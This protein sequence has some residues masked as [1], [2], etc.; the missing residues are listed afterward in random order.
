[1]KMNI[2]DLSTGVV[3]GERLGGLFC[4]EGRP[5]HPSRSTGVVLAGFGEIRRRGPCRSLDDEG[6]APAVA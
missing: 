5:G 2:D 6:P 1:M 4:Y 3:G